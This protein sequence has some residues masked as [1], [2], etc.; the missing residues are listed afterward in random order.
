MYPRSGCI[1]AQA[2]M[3]LSPGFVFLLVGGSWKMRLDTLNQLLSNSTQLASGSYQN[4][5]SYKNR[6][7]KYE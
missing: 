2:L 5:F 7:S 3:K 6:L 4:V 1:F